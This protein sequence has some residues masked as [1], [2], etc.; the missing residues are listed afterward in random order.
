VFDR[1]SSFAQG[2]NRN[3]LLAHSKGTEVT[4]W[5]KRLVQLTDSQRESIFQRAQEG[6]S[7]TLLAR[8][9]AVSP[10]TVYRIIGEKKKEKPVVNSK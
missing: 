3:N 6:V 10:V 2:K 4:M 5:S 7:P 1:S 9:F 8:R